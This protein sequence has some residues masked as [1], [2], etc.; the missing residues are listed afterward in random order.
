MKIQE[1]VNEELYKALLALEP[2]YYYGS[3]GTT[4]E[5]MAYADKLFN[6]IYNLLKPFN[7][8]I[9]PDFYHKSRTKNK[10]ELHCT[11]LIP[12]KGGK[13]RQDDWIEIYAK[14]GTKSQGNSID[15]E[16]ALRINTE[17]INNMEE[18]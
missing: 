16:T 3:V 12:I 9:R 6:Q 7:P 14:R 18:W 2:E 15:P 17:P 8:K 13:K 10:I 1:I 11:T 5:T 4:E